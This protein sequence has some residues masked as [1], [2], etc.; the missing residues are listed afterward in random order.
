MRYIR[1]TTHFP[2]IFG[3]DASGN[4]V[5][6]I[7]ASFAIHIDTESYTGYCLT[8]EIGSPISGSSTQKV[9]TRSSTKSEL[10][11]VGDAIGFVERVSLYCK[12]QVRKYPAEHPF[13]DLGKKNVVLQDNTSTIKM[14]K[15][16]RRVCCLRTRNIHIRYFYAQE[17]VNDGTIVVTYCPMK[18]MVSDYLYKSLQGSLFRT[19]HNTLIDITSEQEIQ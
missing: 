1:T 19:H 3:S 14:M 7:D 8:L 4:I 18:E 6:S 12:K 11:R 17:R 5:W 15:G 9:N 10:V 16:C 2:F 13:K